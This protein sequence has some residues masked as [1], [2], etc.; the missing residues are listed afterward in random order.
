[1][2]VAPPPGVASRDVSAVELRASL[3]DAETETRDY[4]VANFDLGR[5]TGRTPGVNPYP[6]IEP[7]ASG[8]LD[9]GD[10]QRIYWEASGN[11]KG[12]PAV[13]LHG[14][15]GATSTPGRRRSFDPSAYNIVQ[16]DQRGAGRS[17]PHAGD[18]ATDLTTNTTHHLV[19]DMEKIREH[20]GIDRWLVW[21]A[22]WGTALALAYAERYPERVT[23][24]VLVSLALTRSRDVRWFAHD[25]GRFFPA[26]WERFR[27]GVPEAD[28]NADLVA[29][30]NRLLNEHTDPVVRV[31]ASRDWCAWEDA[32]LSL[33]RGYVVPNPCW[34]D[35]RFRIGFA[36]LVTHYFSNAAFLEDDQLLRDAHRLKGIP[37]AIIHGRLDIQGPPDAAWELA[38]RWPD[39]ELV[40][41]D[42]GHTGNDEM[43]QRIL[44]ATE[45][46]KR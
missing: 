39:A 5:R 21:G 22:S 37:G 8:H 26:E 36:R 16:F 28:R 32:L 11:P 20:L 24:I 44:A 13:C 27:A 7:Y 9:V 31:R 33:D 12:R 29:A 4:D 18:L 30:Y 34:A 14:G 15:P 38:R 19:A 6:P 2:N 17:T 41:L 40:L 23:E 3:N 43:M 1:M 46:F 45:R 42:T 25:A 10:D 35:E